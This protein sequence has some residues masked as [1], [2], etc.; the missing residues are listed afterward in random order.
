MPSTFF[1]ALKK[2]TNN[3]L[4][5]IRNPLNEAQGGRQYQEYSSLKEKLLVAPF[6]P[7]FS[8]ITVAV[9]ASKT[10]IGALITIPCYLATGS[11]LS[12][13]AETIIEKTEPM[14]TNGFFSLAKGM[15]SLIGDAANLLVLP[16]RA[17]YNYAKGNS[18]DDVAASVNG[19][20]NAIYDNGATVGINTSRNFNTQ[21]QPQPTQNHW[22][23]ITRQQNNQQDGQQH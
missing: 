18:L 17:V 19:N 12:G 2:L 5:T 14:M 20:G 13:V 10:A 9:C 3:T 4:A 11:F 8:A 15:K 1:S 7:L 6:A 23:N 16:A 22:V 21:Q